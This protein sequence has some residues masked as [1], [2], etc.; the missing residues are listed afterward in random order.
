MLGIVG[1]SLASSGLF[2]T[3]LTQGLGLGCVL[4]ALM[5]PRRK[6][7]ATSPPGSTG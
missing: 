1:L 7:V 3:I 2:T 6:A 4:M 5:P